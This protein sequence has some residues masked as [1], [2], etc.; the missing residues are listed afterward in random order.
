MLH[1]MTLH[2]L[3]MGEIFP[4]SSSTEPSG[5]VSIGLLSRTRTLHV[6]RGLPEGQA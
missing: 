5:Q 1:H 6:Q 3:K 2:I 4:W